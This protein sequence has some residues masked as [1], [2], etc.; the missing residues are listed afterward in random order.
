MTRGKVESGSTV[1]DSSLSNSTPLGPAPPVTHL[2]LVWSAPRC[3]LGR[4]EER[5]LLTAGDIAA[6][7]AMDV[8]TVRDQ[9]RRFG[10]RGT[11]TKTGTAR[12]HRMEVLRWL[13]SSG[14]SIPQQLVPD[15]RVAVV[16][17]PPEDAPEALDAALTRSRSPRPL[18][19]ER[20]QRLIG[21]ALEL[22][23]GRFDAL[24][25]DLRRLP[26]ERV[27]DLVAAVRRSGLTVGIGL[28]GVGGGPDP[29]RRFL[30][31]DGDVALAD[32]NGLGPVLGSLFG[33]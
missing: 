16:G 32:V 4:V 21:A 28:V 3:G 2:R 8:K 1:R 23:S 12:F 11:R 26:A 5:S 29:V 10:L 25:L 6:L 22:A 19:V 20:F 31:A 13:R 24:V 33:G 15:P 17:W 14:R 30:L 9:I 18:H 27:V 7:L